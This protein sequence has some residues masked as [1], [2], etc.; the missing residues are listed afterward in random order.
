MRSGYVTGGL[1][2]GFVGKGDEERGGRGGRAV[3]D[4]R[5]QRLKL[6]RDCQIEVAHGWGK[7]RRTWMGFEAK[8]DSPFDSGTSPFLNAPIRFKARC[9]SAGVY[10]RGI[11]LN[12][13]AVL[14]SAGC[15]SVAVAIAQRGR[16]IN[17]SSDEM[18]NITKSTCLGS[19]CSPIVSLPCR[20]PLVVFL[21]RALTRRLY[22]K[23]WLRRAVIQCW[24][25]YVLSEVQCESRS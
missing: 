25:S 17:M 1:G 21:R 9:I 11:P 6:G 12:L 15:F 2:C 10:V 14:P 22:R 23:T 4:R 8:Q 13:T 16:K 7:H 20:L 19:L 5:R 24:K 18:R 3:R